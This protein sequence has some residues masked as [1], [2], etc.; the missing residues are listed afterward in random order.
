MLQSRLIGNRALLQ[1]PTHASSTDSA[2][3]EWAY[4]LDVHIN[5]FFPLYLWLYLAQLFLVPVVLKDIWVCLWV[6]NTIYLAA[7]V[8]RLP[9]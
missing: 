8:G 9:F 2:S 7:C 4:A 6:G 1:P 5:A 3:V